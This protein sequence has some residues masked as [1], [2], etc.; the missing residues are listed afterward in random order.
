ME[1][2]HKG[3]LYLLRRNLSIILGRFEAIYFKLP[4]I[5]KMNLYEYT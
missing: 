2:N 4:V 1:I 3:F 5:I